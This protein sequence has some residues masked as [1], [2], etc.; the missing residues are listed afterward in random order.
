M[1]C[2]WYDTSDI[3]IYRAR[4]LRQ[5]FH[6]IQT[7]H[8]ELLRRIEELLT[9]LAA[10][11]VGT[12]F[13]TL[14]LKLDANWFTPLSLSLS[15]SLTL[16]PRFLEIRLVGFFVFPFWLHMILL[17]WCG[18]VLD[19]H[20]GGKRIQPDIFQETEVRESKRERERE[21][22]RCKSICIQFQF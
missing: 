8:K 13:S 17:R 20:I 19:K 12:I 2:W 5:R 11:K 21:R 18:T 1:R 6:V 9:K 14:K 7:D 4:T 15:L 16:L 10:L 3:D 22:E